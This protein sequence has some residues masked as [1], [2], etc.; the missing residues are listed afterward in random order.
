MR[1]TSRELRHARD[2][3]LQSLPED[4]QKPRTKNSFREK[5][6]FINV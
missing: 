4:Y 6:N 2:T 5:C 3:E 1:T